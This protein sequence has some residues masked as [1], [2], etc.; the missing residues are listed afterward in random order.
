M[1]KHVLTVERHFRGEENVEDTDHR[2]M[3]RSTFLR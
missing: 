2:I 3:S 1:F